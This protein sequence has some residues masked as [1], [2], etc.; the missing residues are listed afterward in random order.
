MTIEATPPGCVPCRIARHMVK[1]LR[2]LS[3]RIPH[4]AMEKRPESKA[5]LAEGSCGS[6]RGGM[7]L[8]M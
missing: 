1:K 6:W 7:R 3:E 2:S 5:M 8:K 4:A